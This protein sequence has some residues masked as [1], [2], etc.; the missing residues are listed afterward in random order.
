[1]CVHV[2]REDLGPYYFS[3]YNR[4][5]NFYFYVDF[6]TFLSQKIP[7]KIEIVHSSMPIK[8]ISIG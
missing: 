1:M 7:I 8:E 4:N 3:Q 5:K 6:I 2:L